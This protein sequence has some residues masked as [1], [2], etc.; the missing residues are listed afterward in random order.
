VVLLFVKDD[1][2]KD[3]VRTVLDAAGP[4]HAALSQVRKVLTLDSLLTKLHRFANK[5]EL[6]TEYDVMLVDVRILPMADKALGKVTMIRGLKPTPLRIRRNGAGL[7]V[8]IKRAL[9]GMYLMV[10]AGICATVRV[11]TVRMGVE[12]VAAN[13]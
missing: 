9:T 10:P 2:T 12:Q 5:R 11:E 1:T 13:V 8:L 7:P 4:N 6:A 3:L